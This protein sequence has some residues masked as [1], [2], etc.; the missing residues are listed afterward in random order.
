M[1]ESTIKENYTSSKILINDLIRLTR[2]D[3]YIFR[4]ISRRS[5]LNP[6]ICRKY[7]RDT[8]TLVKLKDQEFALL[9]AF[10]QQASNLFHCLRRFDDLGLDVVFAE[11]LPR[12]GAG[13]AVMNRLYRAAGGAVVLCGADSPGTPRAASEQ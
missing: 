4:G 10:R 9:H 1:A 12:S 5:E 11:A 13:D 7:D 3:Q 8:Q 6:S 2:S